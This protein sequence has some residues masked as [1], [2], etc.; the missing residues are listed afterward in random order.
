M[1]VHSFRNLGLVFVGLFLTVS[2]ARADTRECFAIERGHGNEEYSTFATAKLLCRDS[3]DGPA[4]QKEVVCHKSG[5]YVDRYDQQ[6]WN[7]CLDSKQA[8]VRQD[9]IFQGIIDESMTTA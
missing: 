5:P 3:V 9:P 7:W 2:A 1:R 4:Y 8:D 6:Y